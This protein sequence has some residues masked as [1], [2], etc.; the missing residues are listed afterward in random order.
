MQLYSLKWV[1]AWTEAC[2][3]AIS[4]SMKDRRTIDYDL[5]YGGTLYIAV[6]DQLNLWAGEHD[7]SYLFKLGRT[8]GFS[9]RAQSLN[10]DWRLAYGNSPCLGFRDWRL[11]GSWSFYDKE[12]PR[13]YERS[14][15]SGFERILERFDYR[16]VRG[17]THAGNGETEIF[18]FHPDASADLLGMP[19]LGG[20][21]G[22]IVAQMIEVIAAEMKAHRSVR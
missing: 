8:A 7:R 15:A 20:E 22:I 14:I 19:K 9:D 11:L 10:A 21:V 17:D 4:D 1:A 3:P 2:E 16:E 12:D 5:R 6:S 18:R 13:S